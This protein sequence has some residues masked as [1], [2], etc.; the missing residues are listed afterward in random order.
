MAQ[1]TSAIQRASALVLPVGI[2]VA[3]VTAVTFPG[4]GT[5][6]GRL[7]VGP[8]DWASLSVIVIFLITGYSLKLAEVTD[9]GFGKAVV[10][11]V[12][13][14]LIVAPA[15]AWVTV[16]GVAL[17]L[18][19]AMGIA[20][21]ASVSTTNSSAVVTAIVAGGDRTWAAGLT[22]ICVVAGAFTAP[23]AVSAIL[24][25]HASASPGSLLVRVVTIVVVPLVVGW[26][27]GRLVER[28]LPRWVDLVPP[29]AVISVVWVTMSKS[30]SA[31]ASAT[32]LMIG[33][34]I[35]V[36]LVG[37]GVLLG[38]GSLAARPFPPKQRWPVLFV[39]AQKTLPVA[40]SLLIVLTGEAPD[41]VAVAGEAV[42]VCLAWHFLQ[43]LI[44]SV[45]AGRIA[46]RR[47]PT[48]AD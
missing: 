30:A 35:V 43:I 16:R 12:G 9:S 42:L 4:P 45:I 26:V 25:A 38:L 40:L 20:L 48:S 46:S 24:S 1:R 28:Q 27:M 37:H 10:L 11:V 39:T 22:V 33:L 32:A 3:L 5:A 21:M 31:L 36:A 14:N 44:D 15:L 34:V 6:I 23:L 47:V 8:F 7:A 18:G 17:P 13:I 29:L 19:I 2:L 41:L